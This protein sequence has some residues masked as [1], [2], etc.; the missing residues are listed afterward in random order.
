MQ[1]NLTDCLKNNKVEKQIIAKLI[2]NQIKNDMRFNINNIIIAVFNGSFISTP[3]RL[4]LFRKHKIK[5]DISKL[6]VLIM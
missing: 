1:T 5:Y 6:V 2:L 4:F 3:I